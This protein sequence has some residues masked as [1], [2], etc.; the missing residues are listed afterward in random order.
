[1]LAPSTG[2][3]PIQQKGK[4]VSDE[5]SICTTCACM[6][7]NGDLSSLTETEQAEHI[8]AV[9]VTR[10]TDNRMVVVNGVEADFAKTPCQ[11]CGDTLAGA[12]WS[13]TAM[14]ELTD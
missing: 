8:E 10:D 13:A 1:M 6:Y 7:A 5:L 3:N 14:G 2:F 9:I 11:T 4:T 12:R